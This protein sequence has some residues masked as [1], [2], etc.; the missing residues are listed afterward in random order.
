M[1]PKR[2]HI[3]TVC[4]DTILQINAHMQ[5]LESVCVCTISGGAGQIMSTS[6]DRELPHELSPHTT[7]VL[8][9]HKYIHVALN[10]H[11]D[12]YTLYMYIDTCR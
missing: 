9:W 3:H 7:T 10:P 5:P 11:M 12:V 2:M 4:V 6:E 1:F 8:Y